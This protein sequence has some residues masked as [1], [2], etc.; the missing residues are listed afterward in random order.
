M[1]ATE[2]VTFGIRGKLKEVF[3][4]C[5]D[6][7]DTVS[8][9]IVEVV[10]RAHEGVE[11]KRR[12]AKLFEQTTNVKAKLVLARAAG[13][14][15][16]DDPKTTERLATALETQLANAKLEL[17]KSIGESSKIEANF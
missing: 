11:Q 6:N 14:T 5:M 15:T 12:N 2:M 10:K 8:A 16:C 4:V 7:Q 9:T 13:S 1:Y 3:C 17:E